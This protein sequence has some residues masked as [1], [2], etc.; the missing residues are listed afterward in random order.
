LAEPDDYLKRLE[1]RIIAL[2]GTGAMRSPEDERLDNLLRKF[3]KSVEMTAWLGG[4][5]L[6][7][8]PIIAGLWFF[9]DQALSWVKESTT[10]WLG[11]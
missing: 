1:A 9:G 7:V 11:R 8:A 2:E 6:K 3:A 5:C 10:Q 4:M